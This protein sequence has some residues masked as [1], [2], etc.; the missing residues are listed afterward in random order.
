[1]DAARAAPAVSHMLVHVLVL[2]LRQG[3]RCFLLLV[4]TP[5]RPP[6]LHALPALPF[7]TCVSCVFVPAGM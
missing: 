1:V 2:L 5:S 4:Q 6:C 7:T 3:K